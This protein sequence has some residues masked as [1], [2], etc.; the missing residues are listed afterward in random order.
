MCSIEIEEQTYLYREFPKYYVCNSK[1][2]TWTKKKTRYVI[3]HIAIGK[4]DV[5][6]YNLMH[7]DNC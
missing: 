3:G 5:V 1:L 7:I 2:K 4:L 6:N